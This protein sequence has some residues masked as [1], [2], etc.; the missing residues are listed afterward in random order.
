MLPNGTPPP[1]EASIQLRDG[2]KLAYLAVGPSD[3]TPLI[4]CYSASRRSCRAFVSSCSTGQGSD[5]RI[6]SLVLGSSIGPMMSRRQRTSS[7]SNASPS[8]DS[9]VEAPSH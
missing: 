9:L 2:R 3:G 5:A 7:G 6:P 4:H 1:A 8:L